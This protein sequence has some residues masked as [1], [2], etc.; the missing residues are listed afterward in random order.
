MPVCST[1]GCPTLVRKS[2]QC[3]THARHAD[4]VRGSRHQRGYTYQH[5]RLRASWAHRVATGQVN[6]AKCG[7]LIAPDTPWDLGH[8]DDRTQWT[9][10]EHQLCNRQ[11]AGHKAHR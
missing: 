5:T 9:G 6:C 8:T 3:T 1:P 10:P 7:H 11:A 2:G 4:D